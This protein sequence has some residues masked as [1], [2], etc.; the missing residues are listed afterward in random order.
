MEEENLA[1]NFAQISF[2]KDTLYKLIYLPEIEE[3]ETGFLPVDYLAKYTQDQSLFDHLWSQYEDYEIIP[4]SEAPIYQHYLNQVAVDYKFIGKSGLEIQIYGKNIDM[5]IFENK[6]AMIIVETPNFQPGAKVIGFDEN[7][8]I[9]N[10]YF[11]ISTIRKEFYDFTNP[12]ITLEQKTKFVRRKLRRRYAIF[13]LHMTKKMNIIDIKPLLLHIL[14]Y[15]MN[16]TSLEVNL[17]DLYKLGLFIFDYIPE[18]NHLIEPDKHINTKLIFEELLMMDFK[19]IINNPR[20]TYHHINMINNGTN[21]IA[22]WSEHKRLYYLVKN[23]NIQIDEYPSCIIDYFS[24]FFTEGNKRN[25]KQN[26]DLE[27]LICTILNKD[28]NLS[29]KY[30]GNKNLNYIDIPDEIVLIPPVELYKTVYN[31][32]K[33]RYIELEDIFGNAFRL[34]NKT[35]ELKYKIKE[36]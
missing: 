24:M 5:H 25:N 19:T 20:N 3:E 8:D 7:Y 23:N 14:S 4:F 2:E 18:L 34:G 31:L 29:I 13:I 11:Y 21:F 16:I 35:I 15:V 6:S 30:L 32:E 28:L 1:Q 33:P 27:K 22:N 17:T 26:E 36:I 9:T 12:G 10:L